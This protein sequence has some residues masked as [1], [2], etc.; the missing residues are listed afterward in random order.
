MNQTEILLPRSLKNHF[1]HENF[2]KGLWKVRE[3]QNF[4][5]TSS[6]IEI[7]AFQL[8]VDARKSYMRAV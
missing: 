1:Y 7:F 2:E 4:L 3:L 6:S 5:P 8:S